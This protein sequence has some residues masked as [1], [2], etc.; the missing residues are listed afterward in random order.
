MTTFKYLAE[1]ADWIG[2][3]K[4][5]VYDKGYSE[6][7]VPFINNGFRLLFIVFGAFALVNFV[8]AA[9]DFINA[10]GDNKRI[11]TAKSR[12][13]QTI[14]GLVLLVSCFIFAGLVG[15]IFFGDWFFILD[16]NKTIDKL[17]KTP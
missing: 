11:D 7:L 13:T 14:I 9:Y 12:L 17:I 16:I 2:T 10:G 15:Q 6:G 5:P 4:P 1:A 8:L 3:V